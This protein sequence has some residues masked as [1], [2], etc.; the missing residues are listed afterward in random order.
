VDFA[1]RPLSGMAKIGG[2]S[3]F[4]STRLFALYY[5]LLADCVKVILC[6]SKDIVDF[7]CAPIMDMIG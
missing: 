3:S 4:Y 2:G 5:H 7:P 6:F 1:F